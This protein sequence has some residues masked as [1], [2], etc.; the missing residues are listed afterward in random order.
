MKDID[1]TKPGISFVTG[2]PINL[3]VGLLVLS[4]DALFDERE[5]HSLLVIKDKKSARSILIPSN[6]CD[7]CIVN[8]GEETCGLFLCDDGGVW[9]YNGSE[10]EPLESAR[11]NGC[12][13]ILRSQTFA[14]GKLHYVVGGGNTIYI[15][16][17][18]QPWDSF[19]IGAEKEI[20]QY[21]YV[22][23]EKVLSSN[24]GLIYLFGWHG[25]G[26]VF[27][28]E[29]ASLMDLPIGVDLYD[30]ALADN[31]DVYACGDKG[32]AIFGR[33]V[34][35]WKIVK[36]EVTDDKLWGVSTYKE[37]IFLCSSNCLYEV[38]DGELQALAYSESSNVPELFT[39]KLKSCG[40]CVW[41]IGSKQLV[42]YDGANWHEILKLY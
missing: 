23:F 25:V 11:I 34:D 37:K 6:C 7:V 17:G 10:I 15:R 9:I 38:I 12:N 41:S 16:D 31:G 21:K 22:G 24:D 18:M 39:H 28:Q 35:S 4:I 36:N 33:G 42:Q 14:S 32:I 8:D 27:N 2:S 13:E 1:L 3:D 20:E 30:A 40:N 5:P 29:E 19:D 26:Y